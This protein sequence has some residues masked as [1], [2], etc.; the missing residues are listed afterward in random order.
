MSSSYHM[1][2]LSTEVTEFVISDKSGIYV[3]GTLGG[4]GHSKLILK[5]LSNTAT[6]I[7]VDQDKDAINKAWRAL[8]AKWHPD[9]HQGSKEAHRRFLVIS[10]AY[11]YLMTG[12]ECQDMNIDQLADQEKAAGEYR[13]DND[14]GYFA[15]WQENFNDS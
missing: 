6:L 13:L 15:W 5:K 11:R 12:E 2:V 3:D 10:C 7:C 4:G 8:S 14:W 9:R 1:P